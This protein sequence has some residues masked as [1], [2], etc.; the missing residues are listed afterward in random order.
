M[1]ARVVLLVI[2]HYSYFAVQS[3]A[4]GV[5]KCLKPAL[6]LSTAKIDV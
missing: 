3:P 5:W 2:H 6:A 4:G 1:R